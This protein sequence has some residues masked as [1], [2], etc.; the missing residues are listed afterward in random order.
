MAGETLTLD[1]L[2]KAALIHSANDA[3]TAIAEHVGGTVSEFVEM[4][5]ER[6]AELGLTDT[7]FANPHGLDAPD[8]YSKP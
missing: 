7:N 4:M 2:L 8:H 6:A 3:A 1:A 5:N